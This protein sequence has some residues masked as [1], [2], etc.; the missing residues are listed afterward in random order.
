MNGDQN[1]DEQIPDALTEKLREVASKTTILV[2]SSIDQAVL[3]DVKTHFRQT[4]RERR[5]I[6]R[7]AWLAAAACVALLA[8]FGLRHLSQGRYERAD[9][10][11]NGRVD[12][13]DAFALARRIEQSPPHGVDINKDGLVNKADVDAI[14]AQAVKLKKGV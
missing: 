2:P 3:S 9:I 14:A 5:Q 10:D 7:I 11:H 8:L 13:L 4:R 12:I 6:T 1:R